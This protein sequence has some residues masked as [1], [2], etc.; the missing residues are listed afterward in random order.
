MIDLYQK[1]IRK[2]QKI[3]SE[4]GLGCVAVCNS[5]NLYYMTGY[6]AKK[7]ER[8]LAA[9]IPQE[10]EP[11]LVVPAIHHFSSQKECAIEDQ[12]SWIDG[13]NVV[14][15]VKDIL[16]QCGAEGEKIAIDDTFE[17]R[18]FDIVK[19]ASPKSEFVLGSNIFTSLRMRKN[20]EEIEKMKA[21]GKLSDEVTKMLIENIMSGKSEAEMKA[22]IELWLTKQGMRDGFSNLIAAGIHCASPHHTCTDYVPQKGDAVWVDI[23]GAYDH[24]WS[25]ITRS[26][27]IGKPSGRYVYIY[28]H[29]REAQRIAFESIKPGVRACDVHTTAWN[30]LDKY[31]L[32]HLFTHRLGH[33]MGLDGHELPNLSPDNEMLLEPGMTFSCEPGCYEPESRFGVRIEDTVCVTETGAVSF[34]GFTKDL[35]IVE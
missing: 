32:A 2:A 29:V 12:R 8:L 30:Y 19:T 34:N 22:D 27:H 1:R 10:G 28:N 7:C 35:I 20:Q 24:Y 21:S 33:G 3:M 14:G 26:F 5:P 18:Q 4:Q 11:V 13:D 9:F 31:D 15:I 17:F 16:V 23:G 25:D 6:S